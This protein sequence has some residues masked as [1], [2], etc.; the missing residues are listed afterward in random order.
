MYE[1]HDRMHANDMLTSLTY[2][3]DQLIQ[4]GCL[5]TLKVCVSHRLR[6]VQHHSFYRGTMVL[7][8]V[9]GVQPASLRQKAGGKMHIMRGSNIPMVPDVRTWLAVHPTLQ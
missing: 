3:V 8:P 5:Y 7:R 2:L 4:V 6:E 1:L 9:R